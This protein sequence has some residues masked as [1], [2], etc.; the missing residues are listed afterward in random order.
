MVMETRQEQ[1][2]RGRKIVPLFSR[3]ANIIFFKA[4]ANLKSEIEKTYLGCLWWVLE[5]LLQTMVF[6]LVFTQVM[7]VRTEN[8]TVF[9]YIG[10]SAYNYFSAAAN[11]G[12]QALIQNAGL[13]QQVYIPKAVYVMISMVNLTWKFIF[14]FF[15]LILL[16]SWQ[17]MPVT[18]AYLALVPLILLQI[19][20]AIGL[21]LPLAVGVAYFQDG[22]AVVATLMSM[23]VWFSGVFYSASQVPDHL[24][25]YFYLNPMA[26]VIEAYRDILYVGQWPEWFLFR[27]IF[28]V[29][30]P[31]W[32]FGLWLMHK[33]ERRVTK[34]NL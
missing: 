9:L 16:V 26:C 5:P 4:Y 31:L 1:T 13:M 15:A 6:Y 10:M 22:K 30:V 32:I 28:L 11:L 20:L 33:V 21:A 12:C 2:Q 19:F 14:S 7:H 34:L 18:W 17:H 27:N 23:G 24:R 29:A 25:T 8:F 3:Y